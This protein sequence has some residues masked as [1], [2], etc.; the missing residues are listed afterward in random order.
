MSFVK[1]SFVKQMV[2]RRPIVALG[3]LMS[4]AL[5]GHAVPVA[6]GGAVITA[7][8]TAA[9]Q[10]FLGG[11]VIRDAIQ[12]FSVPDGAGGILARGWI[13]DRV[14]RSAITGR[15]HFYYRLQNFGGY[16]GCIAYVRKANFGGFFTDVNYRLDG[17]GTIGMRRVFRSGAP[18]AVLTYDYTARPIFPGEQSRFTFAATN[19]PRYNIYGLTSIV[20]FHPAVGYRSTSVRTAQPMW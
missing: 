1:L 20:A 10:P 3:V 17:L 14:V 18:G 12:P 19:A 15:L 2:S 9:A 8:T 4:T 7:G 11:V 16:K 6:P 5:S 13:Q